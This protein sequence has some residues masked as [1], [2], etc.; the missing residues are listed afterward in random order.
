MVILR[1]SKLLICFKRRDFL[2][3]MLIKIQI[4]K[5]KIKENEL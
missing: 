4:T 5:I 2:V 3:L 1:F